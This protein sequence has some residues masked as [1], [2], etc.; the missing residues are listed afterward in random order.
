VLERFKPLAEQLVA[1]GHITGRA[2]SGKVVPAVATAAGQRYDVVG[3]VAG[4]GEI[5][6]TVCAA[7]VLRGEDVE[8]VLASV[9]SDSGADACSASVV[10]SSA[11]CRVKAPALP[12][13]LTIF[14]WVLRSA[15]LRPYRVA[16]FAP[17]S[18]AAPTAVEVLSVD[19]KQAMAVGADFICR[20]RTAARRRVSVAPLSGLIGA[21]IS[22]V[23]LWIGSASGA[24]AGADLFG[25]RRILSAP[26]SP[27]SFGVRCTVRSRLFGA[28]LL[29]IRRQTAGAVTSYGEVLLRCREQALASTADFCIHPVS[30]SPEG[31][32]WPY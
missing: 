15:L 27:R 26:G 12:L 13:V 3:V 21:L 20:A 4:D 11:S 28:A 7:P 32:A 24:P 23:P 5:G 14:R 16:G 10:L 9:V 25:A 8:D 29:A 1:L 31:D 22:P 2:G 30:V 19:G 17:R 6:A 18:E